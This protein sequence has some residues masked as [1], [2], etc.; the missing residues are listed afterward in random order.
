MP[1][2]H[3]KQTTLQGMFRSLKLSAISFMLT[4]EPAAANRQDGCISQLRNV[5]VLEKEPF[6]GAN[7]FSIVALELRSRAS[8]G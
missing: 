3:S 2:A 5:Q 7:G 4:G 8:A 6:A 1:E